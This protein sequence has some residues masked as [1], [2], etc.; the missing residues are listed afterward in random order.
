MGNQEATGQALA[1]SGIPFTR[2]EPL[3][4]HTSFEVGGPAAFFCSP[5]TPAQLRQALSIAQSQ[6]L[7]HYV[8]GRGSNVIFRDEGY[9]GLVICP[10][11]PGFS[12]VRQQG[13]RLCA[14]AAVPVKQLCSAAQQAGLAGLS[15]AYGIPG[16]VGG[17]VYMNA[18]AYGGEMACVLESVHFL[19]ESLEER[20]LP[21]TELSLGYRQSLFQQRPWVILEACFALETGNPAEIQTQMDDYMRRREEKQPLDK[22]SAGSAFKRPPGAFAGALIDQC[23]LRGYRVGDAAISEKHCGFIVNLG[24][25]SCRDI[26]ALADEVSRM[27]KEQTGYT[28]EKEIRVVDG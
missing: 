2:Q 20:S 7:P 12:A 22:P 14:G 18:G 13:S 24:R 3:A 28:L 1:S 9:P 4:K 6:G 17:A 19:D 16:W 23:G 27:V 11:G 10:G 15:F 21:A 5:E 26:L 8:L 25:A